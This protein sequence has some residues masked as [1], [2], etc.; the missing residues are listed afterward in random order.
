M[1]DRRTPSNETLVEMIKGLTEKVDVRF[2]SLEQRMVEGFTGI[3]RRQDLAN[4]RTNKLEEKND[5]QEIK[6]SQICDKVKNIQRRDTSTS[7]KH[8][9]IFKLLLTP[10]LTVVVILLLAYISNL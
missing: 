8:W 5:A 6:I 7:N 3:H 4:H 9:E 1:E 2:E 10:S